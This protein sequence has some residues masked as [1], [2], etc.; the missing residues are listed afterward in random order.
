MTLKNVAIA[1]GI[2]FACLLTLTYLSRVIN[3]EL[4][5]LMIALILLA[6]SY[7][8]GTNRRV[9]L[10]AII[11]TISGVVL[12]VFGLLIPFSGLTLSIAALLSAVWL[13]V[14]HWYGWYNLRDN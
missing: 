14:L 12:P 7:G 13:A 6:L 11:C 2:F 3:A 10:A 5:W 4:A 9:S 1:G 8:L